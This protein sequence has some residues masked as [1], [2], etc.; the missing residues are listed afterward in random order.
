MSDVK[1][2]NVTVQLTG[3]DGN[4]FTILGLVKNALKKEAGQEVADAYFDEATEG[5]Y[6]D[7]L[8]TTMKWVNVE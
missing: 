3:R 2:P 4:A 6:N 7:L 1:Y 5:D 8:A